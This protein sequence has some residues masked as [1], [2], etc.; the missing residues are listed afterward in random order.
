MKTNQNIS[1]EIYKTFESLD[2]I[3]ETKVSPFF[4]DKVLRNVFEA[5][6]EVREP[7]L[8]FTPKLQFATLL[9]FVLLNTFALSNLKTD[10]YSENVSNF[11]EN[12]GLYSST[13]SS[14]LK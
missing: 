4:K 6:E 2:K 1:E 9:V 10:T 7:F 14:I 5:K 8:W 3:Q 12:Y 13:D 11:A